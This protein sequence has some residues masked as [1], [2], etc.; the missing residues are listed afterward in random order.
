MQKLHVTAHT[1]VFH[2]TIT[3]LT[4]SVYSA[5]GTLPNFFMLRDLEA[6]D[7]RVWT[8]IV[9]GQACFLLLPHQFALQKAMQCT[10]RS[11]AQ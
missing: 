10:T 11:H 7:L 2:H 5:G 3:S 9:A 8:A 4:L 6:S 1:R